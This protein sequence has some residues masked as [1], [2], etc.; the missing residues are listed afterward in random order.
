MGECLLDNI[1]SYYL[2]SWAAWD[3]LMGLNMETCI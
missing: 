2:A 1:A 3:I